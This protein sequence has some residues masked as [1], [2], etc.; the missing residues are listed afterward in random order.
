MS[1]ALQIVTR[2]FT[3]HAIAAERLSWK[4]LLFDGTRHL[5]STHAEL[6]PGLR[7]LTP[8]QQKY[9]IQAFTKHI[10]LLSHWAVRAWDGGNEGTINKSLNSSLLVIKLVAC[11]I[12]FASFGCGWNSEAYG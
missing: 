2:P 6:Q 5:M 7:C 9:H 10:V 3:L 4:C 8:G 12:E 11:S 1:K